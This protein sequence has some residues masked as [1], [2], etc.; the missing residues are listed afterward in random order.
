MANALP[1]GSGWVLLVYVPRDRRLMNQ[2]AADHSQTIAGGIPIVALD[3][4]EHAYHLDF[5]A[6][7]AAYI[8]AFMRNIDWSAAQTRYEDAAKVEPPRPLEQKEFADVP[9]LTPEDVKS[10]D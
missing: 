9:S 6:N 3:M 10:D 4:Y 1:G 2:Y 7:A 5:G 8:D